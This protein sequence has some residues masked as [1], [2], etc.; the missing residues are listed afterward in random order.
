MYLAIAMIS[1]FDGAIHPRMP[2]PAHIPV[3]AFALKLFGPEITDLSSGRD[4]PTLGHGVLPSP[5]FLFQ[6]FLHL[7]VQFIRN[8][9]L[10]FSFHLKQVN[11]SVV[12][13]LFLFQKVWRVLPVVRKCSYI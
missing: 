1:V 6:A 2:P 9:V 8:K 4:F 10:M 3:P 5:A 12:D 13:Y 11:L 7:L